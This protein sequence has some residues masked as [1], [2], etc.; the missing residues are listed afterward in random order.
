[1]KKGNLQ[2]LGT[3]GSVGIPV[4]G[5]TCAVCHSKDPLNKRLRPSILLKIA[6]KQILVDPGPDLRFQ[7]LWLGIDHLDG[8]ML[9]HAHYDHTAGF[10]DLRPLCY[11]RQKPLPILLSRETSDDVQHRFFLLIRSHFGAAACA[12]F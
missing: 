10:D 1:M 9:T 6:Q 8:L 7:A 4:V 2:F 5:C 3:G 12:S 11:K